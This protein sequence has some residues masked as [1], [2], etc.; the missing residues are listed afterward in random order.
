LD[1][2]GCLCLGQQNAICYQSYLKWDN[3]EWARLKE[4]TDSQI[5][6]IR[7][8]EQNNP[9]SLLSVEDLPPTSP[10]IRGLKLSQHQLPL[11][12]PAISKAVEKGACVVREPEDC[13][14]A[15]K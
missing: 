1:F 9:F 10:Q 7:A 11:N 14:E 12:Q 5:T 2:G 15:E 4:L 6:K 8:E 3:A 13:I